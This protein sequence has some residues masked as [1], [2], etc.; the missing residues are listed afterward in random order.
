MALS[1]MDLKEVVMKL[2]GPVLPTGS[3]DADLTRLENLMTLT[4]V[5][6]RLVFEVDNAAKYATSLADSE[7]AIGQHAHGFLV[8]LSEALPASE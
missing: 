6:D 2:V 3:H 8:A 4:R 7:K 5:I 1:D